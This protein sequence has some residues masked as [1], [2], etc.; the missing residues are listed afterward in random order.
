[1]IRKA[2][3]SDK[4]QLL[5]LINLVTDRKG[6]I[7]RGGLEKINKSLQELNSPTRMELWFGAKTTMTK[8]YKIPEERIKT[9]Q[10]ISLGKAAD[11]MESYIYIFQDEPT[12]HFK[13]YS[14][15]PGHFLY[16]TGEYALLRPL[17]EEVKASI[18]PAKGVTIRP[19]DDIIRSMAILMF[20]DESFGVPLPKVLIK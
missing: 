19:T 4:E 18:K 20:S 15:A 6:R 2:Q 13:E 11:G 10:F 3:D 1:M 9:R 8:R 5:K 12:P 7:A 16:G 17:V 14:S